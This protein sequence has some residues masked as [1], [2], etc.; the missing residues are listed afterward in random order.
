ME[1]TLSA[2]DLLIRYRIYRFFAERCRAPSAQE[3]AV[4]LGRTEDQVSK[5]FQKLHARHLIFLE[6]GKE[7]TGAIRIANP[8]SAVPT[9]YRVISGQNQWWA[10]C[11]W[12]S[13][14]ISAA[15]AVD[16]QIE[17]VLPDGERVLLKVE[18]GRV[19]GKQHM[20]YF[21]LPCRS[22]H[23]DLVFT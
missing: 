1:T 17:A 9:S 5:S 10:N 19:D 21:P 15:L 6:P 7:S 3:L 12:D 22:W 11:A 23:D 4:L 8:F 20:V 16:A 18:N 13:L 14:G 2:D